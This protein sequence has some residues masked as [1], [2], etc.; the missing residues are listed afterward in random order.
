M[1][2]STGYRL[3]CLGLMVL[4]TAAC[5]DLRRNLGLDRNPPDEFRIVSRAPLSVPPDFAMRPPAPG[6][7]RPQ[8]PAQVDRARQALLGPGQRPN[9]GPQGGERALLNRAGADR[10]DPNIRDQVNREA[11]QTDLG[12]QTLLERLVTGGTPPG[13][14]VD[15]AREAQRLREAAAQGRPANQGETPTIRRRSRGLLD[16]LF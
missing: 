6:T 13:T 10:A 7:P 8:E 15:P 9:A 11:G 2:S 5:Q 12:D 14:V 4:A 16:R 3:A 1:N